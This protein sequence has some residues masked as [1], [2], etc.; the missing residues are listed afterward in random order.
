LK[1]AR[2]NPSA[3]NKSQENGYF[4]RLHFPPVK[5]GVLQKIK[6]VSAEWLEEN[7]IKEMVF[8]QGLFNIPELQNQLII[9]IENHEEKVLAFLNLVPDYAK[10]EMTYDLIRKSKDAPNGIVDFLMVETI[11]Y[12]M[13]RG[14][15]YFN[16]GFAPMSGIEKGRDFPEKS[17]KFAYEKI[18]SFSTFKG[19][20]DFKDKYEPD[21]KNRYIIYDHHYDLFNIPSILGKV[22]KL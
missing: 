9:T 21:W 18:R 7:E 6:T 16:L 15:R 20:R 8:S 13:S 14:H 1:G 3:C 12:L 17:I 10:G 2:K 19:L 22:V 5:E 4:P 11:K